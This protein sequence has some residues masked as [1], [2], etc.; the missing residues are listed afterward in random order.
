MEIGDFMFQLTS[1]ESHEQEHS[2]SQTL[3]SNRNTMR[4]QNVTASKR[5]VRH[6]PYAFTEHGAIMAATI[7][8]SS[9]AVQMSVFVVRAFVKMRLLLSERKELVQELAQLEKK[10]TER[11]DVHEIA[12]VDVLQRLMQMLDPLPSMPQPSKPPIGFHQ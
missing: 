4:S 8:N 7:L 9:T 3:I 12:I 6:Q 10:L 1:K 11:L 5:N 2:R